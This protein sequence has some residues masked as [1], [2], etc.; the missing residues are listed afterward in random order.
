MNFVSRDCSSMIG[1]IC[2]IGSGEEVIAVQNTCH[3][4][5]SHSQASAGSPA[6]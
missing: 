5:A 4:L 6:R 2:A 1:S 3:A